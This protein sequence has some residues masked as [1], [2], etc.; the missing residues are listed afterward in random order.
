MSPAD[1]Q[2][3]TLQFTLS[4][5][6]V[7]NHT[8]M[9]T[10]QLHM[11][12]LTSA[13]NLASLGTSWKKNFESWSFSFNSCRNREDFLKWVFAKIEMATAKDLKFYELYTNESRAESHGIAL[14][15]PHLQDTTVCP[16]VAEH[17]FITVWTA[18][19][20]GGQRNT[21]IAQA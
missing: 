3:L 13:L 12:P 7:H 19:S 14:I 8:A 4:L 9:Q 2:A 21:T 18:I 11:M 10:S 20:Y 17:F 16:K 5:A 15:C 1:S 6:M